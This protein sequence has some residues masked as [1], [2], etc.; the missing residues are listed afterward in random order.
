[1]TQIANQDKP[2]QDITSSY[3]RKI[4]QFLSAW[5][6]NVNIKFFDRPIVVTSTRDGVVI[7]VTNHWIDNFIIH[8]KI[9]GSFFIDIPP[10]PNI[11]ENLD[12]QAIWH[13]AWYIQNAI[14]KHFTYTNT[15]QQYFSLWDK[16]PISKSIN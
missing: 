1:M 6:I 3:I 10:R 2:T 7:D 5:D 4:E 8:H 13:D 16:Y 12:D 11:D 14:L 9:F 15:K